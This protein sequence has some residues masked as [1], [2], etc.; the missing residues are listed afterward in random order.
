L[1]SQ[2]LLAGDTFLRPKGRIEDNTI[3]F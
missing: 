3:S 1:N 2:N